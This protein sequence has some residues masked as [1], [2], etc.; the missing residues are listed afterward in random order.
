MVLLSA[1]GMDVPAITKVAFTSEDR[2]RDVIGNFNADGTS[3]GTHGTDEESIMLLVS[4]SP[5]WP[6]A[7]KRYGP[8]PSARI[9]PTG[10]ATPVPCSGQ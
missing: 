10:Q 3:R 1:Q 8:Q 6:A 2:V 9:T 7:G 5:I 4:G